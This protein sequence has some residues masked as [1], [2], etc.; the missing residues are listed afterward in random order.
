[1][2]VQKNIGI[3]KLKVESL[4]TNLQ[5]LILEEKKTRDLMLGVL[6]ILKHMPGHDEALQEI[7][8]TYEENEHKGD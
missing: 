4:T 8:K 3:L 5:S 7:K 6:Q 1:M 2:G